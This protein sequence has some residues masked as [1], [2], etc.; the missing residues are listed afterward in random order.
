MCGCGRGVAHE[1]CFTLMAREE[2][3]S[4][5]S[6]FAFEALSSELAHTICAHIG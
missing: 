2:G 5:L 6:V 1:S 3:S 4:S